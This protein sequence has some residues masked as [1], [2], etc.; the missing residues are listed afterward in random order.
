ME[1]PFE[2]SCKRKCLLIM[3]RQPAII[4]IRT[5][6]FVVHVITTFVGSFQIALIISIHNLSF[7]HG[8]LSILKE[9]SPP[10]NYGIFCSDNLIRA[11]G[12]IPMPRT[13]ANADRHP[14]WA[15]RG[16]SMGDLVRTASD[17]AIRRRLRL[18]MAAP[19]LSFCLSPISVPAVWVNR[20]PRGPQ[21]T[22][23]SFCN[24]VL[25]HVPSK[26]IDE[27]WDV[28]QFHPIIRLTMN[29]PIHCLA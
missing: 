18:R 19:R 5:R 21:I 29:W 20:H 3:S 8:Q 12:K 22:S 26:I 16:A 6:T 17:A 1:V 23:H 4:Q 14:N 28:G 11:D 13:H 7:F 2:I 24:L 10:D 25:V 27:L 9:V 15:S